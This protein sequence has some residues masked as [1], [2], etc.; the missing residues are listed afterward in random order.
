MGRVLVTGGAGF[1]GSHVVEACL[2]AGY[3]VAVVDD[4]SS[5]KKENLPEGVPLYQVDIADAEAVGRVFDLVR[6][7]KVVHQAAQISVSRSVREPALDARINV[8]GLL[9]VL[10]AAVRQGV[11]AFIFASSGGVLYGDVFEP[12]A[13]EHPAAPVSP[14][15]IAKLAGEMY[16]AFFAREHG[17]RCAALRY[18]NVYGPRQDPHGEAG[19]VAIFLERLLAGQAPI[20]NGD[21]RYVRDYVYVEDVARAN[22]LALEG[23]WEGFRAYNVGTGR[24]TDVN[25]LE[26]RLRS[27]LTE[28]LRGQ[29]RKVDLPAA[30]YGPPRPGDL[31]SSLLDAGKIARELGWRPEVPLEEGLKRTAAWFA[32]RNTKK[33]S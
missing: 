21:G 11:R 24:G 32:G 4:L 31:R 6:P 20:I 33:Y 29:G 1:I 17:L 5:G 19:V 16:L 26:G 22:L 7:E 28:I 12:A 15:G 2:A 10:E 14:Y 13:E 9:N 30:T 18:G 8:L 25:E 23:E 27:A 3:E